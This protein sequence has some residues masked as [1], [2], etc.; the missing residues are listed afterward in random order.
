MLRKF[1]KNNKKG[2]IDPD[3]I[4]LDSSNI[5]S[6]N[7][8]QFEGRIEKP[9][10]MTSL[11]VMG[12]LFV[13]LVIG[14]TFRMVNLQIVDGKD[15]LKISNQ[16]TLK[17]D[18]IFADRG[19]I[20]DRNGKELVWNEYVTGEDFP[21]R[22]YIELEGLS[23]LLG[24]IKYPKKDSS[25]FFYSLET[26]GGD[27]IEK[28]FDEKLV[29]KN[30]V[31]LT[32]VDVQ[33][34]IH[35]ESSIIPPI[36]G[37]EINLSIDADVQDRLSHFIARAVNDSGFQGGAGIIMD[38]QSGEV[39]SIVTYPQYDSEVMTEG[40]DSNIISKYFTNQQKPFLD[41][42]ISGL[43]APG[44]IVKPFIALGA[45]NEK[46]IS[47][48]KKIESKGFI[49]VPNPYDPSKPSIFKDWKV[50]GW[51]NIQEAIAVSSDVYF[52]AVGG[53]YKDQKGL[54]ITKIDEYLGKF[55]FGVKT[56][57]FFEGPSGNIPTPEWKAKTFD[58]EP[59][60]LGNTYHTS[61]GQYG[62]QVTPT[63]VVRA[64]TGI[65]NNGKI[66]SPVILKGQRGEVSLVSGIDEKNYREVKA[67]MRLAVTNGTAIA[68]NV[69]G[70]SAGAKT[71][72]AEVG[73]R[74]DK[75][76]SWVEGFFPFD[77]PKYV[78]AVVLESGPTSYKISAM[79][80]MGSVLTWIRDNRPEY[81]GKEA[82]GVSEED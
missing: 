23:N 66:V 38:S 35:S 12:I 79:Q 63:Q 77:N 40:K 37:E 4:F 73:V 50:N 41:R 11:F 9:I 6:Y 62:F 43:Y 1:F 64:L 46:I 32:E 80:V 55:L 22:K 81:L 51:T 44:S 78:F 74:K 39:L 61:I 33:G 48:E 72:T 54:G 2:N 20:M 17:K 82:R 5:P 60:V 16:N 65:V 70:T 3:E 8:D 26:S 69:S 28:Y 47:P 36:H 21:R 13:F 56:N 27:G 14:F 30:G 71:G 18:I 58:G 45:L 53:G 10:S 75:V 68:L 19:L 57:D 15:Y 52:Y 59:W 49:T 25:G 34:N 67:G 76:N 7:K 31:K 24:H 42:A 29:G